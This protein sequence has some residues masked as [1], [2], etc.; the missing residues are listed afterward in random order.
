VYI[1]KK[2]EPLLGSIF[3]TSFTRKITFREILMQSFFWNEEKVLKKLPLYYRKLS[4]YIPVLVDTL[5][6][7]NLMLPKTN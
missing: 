2:Q 3:P 5:L 7:N 6:T 4:M 1:A